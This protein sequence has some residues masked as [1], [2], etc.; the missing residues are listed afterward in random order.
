[1]RVSSLKIDDEFTYY[2]VKYTV[3]SID[4]PNISIQRVDGDKKVREVDYLELITNPSFSPNLSIKKDIDSERKKHDSHH[5]AFLD[6]L[7]DDKREKA[8]ERYE[9]IKP[10][11]I[12]EKARNGDFLSS[13]TFNGIY[14]EY[15]LE[16]EMI[17]DLS[18]EQ[19]F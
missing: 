17:T 5:R 4:P 18:K 2:G 15:L 13:I 11:L 7:P 16:G 9:M 14:K 19:L 12:F 3:F 1:M 10:L 6:T 8:S